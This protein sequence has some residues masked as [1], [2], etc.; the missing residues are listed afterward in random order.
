MLLF[1]A[2]ISLSRK[3]FSDLLKVFESS[4]ESSFE[5]FEKFASETVTASKYISKLIVEAAN[6]L[7]SSENILPLSGEI[8]KFCKVLF[9][10]IFL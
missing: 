2:K 9:L 6:K 3:V 4:F 10:A 8:V 7:P 1:L 5:Y